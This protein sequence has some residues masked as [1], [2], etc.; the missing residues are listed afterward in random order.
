MLTVDPVL[1]RTRLSWLGTGP[2][3]ATL[4]AVKGELEKLAYLR[5]LDADTLDLWVLPAERRRFLAGVGRRRGHGA[6]AQPV[7]GPQRLDRGRPAAFART[8]GLT[9]SVPTDSG[10]S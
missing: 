4:A 6:A 10:P 8:S 5:G 2:V 7:A 1:G 3:A 9:D